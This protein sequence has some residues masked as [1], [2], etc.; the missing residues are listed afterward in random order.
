MT[1][2][3]IGDITI[4][5]FD[6]ERDS[7]RVQAIVGEIWGGG[8]DALMEKQYGVIG[9]RPW[10]EWMSESVL[11]YLKA[12]GT[13]SFVAE[14]N[15]ELIGFCSYVIDE[16]RQKGTVG[17]N[18]VALEHQGQ[19]IGTAMLDF[20]MSRIRAEGMVYAAVIVADNEQH[21]PAR[22]NYEKHGFHRLMGL[23][24][25]VQKL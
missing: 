10:A 20:V 6:A 2:H 8:D 25:M 23:Y 7:Q 16:A 15:G 24:Y 13:R 1:E 5:P 21:A 3:R 17:Y 9:G 14:R 12:D 11:S 22:R 19:R 18:G 4:R